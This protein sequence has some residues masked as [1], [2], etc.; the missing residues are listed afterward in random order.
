M[1]TILQRLL[2]IEGVSGA[3]LVDKQG[4]VMAA[5]LDG[6][7]CEVLGAMAAAAYDAAGRYIDQL[8]LGPVRHTIFETRAGSVQVADGGDVLVVV[9]CADTASLGRVRIEATRA[10]EQLQ[11]RALSY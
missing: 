3:L 4:L 8:G 11:Q 10:G 6:D 1:D 7:E 5:T 2:A 9:R